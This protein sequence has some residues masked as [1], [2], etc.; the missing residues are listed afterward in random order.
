[1]QAQEI[2]LLCGAA[3]L[4]GAINSIAGGGTLLTF[5]A[6]NHILSTRY[7]A[8]MVG[9]VANATSTFALFPGSI[10]AVGAYRREM[11]DSREWILL[12]IGPSLLGGLLGSLLLVAFPEAFG[13]LVP[14]LILTAAILF[15]FQPTIA[16]WTG[17]GQEHAPATRSMRWA[18]AACQFG[19][20]VYGGYFG[21][22]IGILMLSGLAMLGLTNIHRMNGLK[23]LFGACINGISIIVFIVSGKIDWPTALPMCFAGMLGGWLG[24]RVAQRMNKNAVRGIVVVIGFSLATFYFYKQFTGSGE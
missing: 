22:G 3:L 10:A 2:L 20:S 15:A 9:A 21:A 4:S 18:M 12:L 7:P 8:A 16:R 13:R 19:V 5:P 11:A 1:M 6:L 14:W 24:A 23:S 17:I